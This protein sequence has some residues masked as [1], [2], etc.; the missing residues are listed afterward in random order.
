[1]RLFAVMLAVVAALQKPHQK[2]KPRRYKIKNKI[3]HT[4]YQFEV[5]LK[6][7]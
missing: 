4:N 5:Y 1:M 6:K 7:D 2:G 3:P